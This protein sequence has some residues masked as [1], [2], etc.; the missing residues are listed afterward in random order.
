[1]NTKY[2]IMKGEEDE[3][4][5]GDQLSKLVK[6]FFYLVSYIVHLLLV[7]YFD[8]IKKIILEISIYFH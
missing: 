8:L 2:K 7:L 6:N 1:M 3:S 5:E 4:E